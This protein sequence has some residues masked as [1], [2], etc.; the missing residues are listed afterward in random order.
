MCTCMADLSDKSLL[1]CP[2]NSMHPYLLSLY[3]HLYLFIFIHIYICTYIHIYIYTYIYINL[4]IYMYIWQTWATRFCS[5]TLPTPCILTFPPHIYTYINTYI[6][7]YV[8]TYIH[9]YIYI[10]IFIYIYICIYIY[11]YMADLSDESLLCYPV[12]SMHPYLSS[13]AAAAAAAG[14]WHDITHTCTSIYFYVY[15]HI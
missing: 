8:H 4:Y 11:V 6:H 12:N 13:S 1:C 15:I 5:A 7:T 10:Y 9:I 2:V 14:E 3:I